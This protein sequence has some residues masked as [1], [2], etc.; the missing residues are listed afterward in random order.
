MLKIKELRTEKGLTQKELAEKIDSTNKNIWAYENLGVF[1]SVET[2]IKLADVFDCSLE[3]LLGLA[4]EYESVTINLNNSL[5]L[6]NEETT[7]LNDFRSLERSERTQAAE[8]VHYLASKRGK[9]K[10]A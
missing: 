4:E 5:K 3:Y 6:T 1:P 9:N 8:Y 10:N 2:L 7:L